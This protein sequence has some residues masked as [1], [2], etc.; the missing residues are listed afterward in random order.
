MSREQASGAVDLDGGT[1][2]YSL[3][4]VL[5]EMLAG[6]TPFIGPTVQ[7]IIL[8][9]FTQPPPPLHSLTEG[10]P[11]WVEQAVMKA[12]AKEPGERFATAAEF[13]QALKPSD[14]LTTPPGAIPASAGPPTSPPQTH[15]V[16]AILQINPA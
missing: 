14:G 3:G 10:V 15:S 9:C 12:L 8:Q 7:A 4:C 1:A 2:V 6:R 16:L 13:G 5:Y 11:D